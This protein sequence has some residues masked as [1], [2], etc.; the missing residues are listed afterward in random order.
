MKVMTVKENR[1]VE[2]HGPTGINQP[3][4]TDTSH[5]TWKE[6]QCPFKHTFEPKRTTCFTYPKKDQLPLTVVVS[7]VVLYLSE[8][9]KS[10]KMW[11]R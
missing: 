11:R 8:L 7:D 4:K 6:Y 5:P 1:R 10:T 2:Q 3:R 9:T